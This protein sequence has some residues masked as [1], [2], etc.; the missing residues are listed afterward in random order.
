MILDRFAPLHVRLVRVA[1]V[2]ALVYGLAAVAACAFLLAVGLDLHSQL[3]V[4]DAFGAPM[5]LV[6]IPVA[7]CYGAVIAA[8]GWGALTASAGT[9]AAAVALAGGYA[10][11]AWAALSRSLADAPPVMLTGAVAVVLLSAAVLF[12]LGERRAGDVSER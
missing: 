1:G 6:L 12:A 4:G 10:L 2:L 5:V 7:F 9:A 8:L 3:G 11:I